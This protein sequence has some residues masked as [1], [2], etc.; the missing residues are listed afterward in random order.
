MAI[1][2]DDGEVIKVADQA[3]AIVEGRG[4]GE[5]IGI[6]KIITIR[7]PLPIAVQVQALAQKSGK[8]RNS[9]IGMLLEVAIEAVRERLDASTIQELQ[10]FEQEIWSDVGHDLE[11][12]K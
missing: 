7:L 10:E 4:K 3:A 11:A 8:S 2:L 1:T 6:T 9:T 5:Y 12:N